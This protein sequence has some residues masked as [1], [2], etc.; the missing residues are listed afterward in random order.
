[1]KLLEITMYVLVLL[2][3]K[4]E[5]INFFIVPGFLLTINDKNLGEN[6]TLLIKSTSLNV[7]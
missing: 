7:S 1:M 6:I 2:F 3:Y 5:S 4:S